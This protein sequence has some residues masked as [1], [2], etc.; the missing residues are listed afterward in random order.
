MLDARWRLPAPRPAVLYQ[1]PKPYHPSPFKL[2]CTPCSLC[3]APNAA[4]LGIRLQY[5][6]FLQALY[7][8]GPEAIC[9][10]LP[11]LRHVPALV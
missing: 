2:Q 6:G 8:D 4:A 10:Q 7:Y 5:R 11:S 3:T 1:D 9:F